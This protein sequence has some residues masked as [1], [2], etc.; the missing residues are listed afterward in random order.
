[1]LMMMMQE[2]D[3]V[4]IDIGERFVTAGYGWD[5]ILQ[6]QSKVRKTFLDIDYMILSGRA[7]VQQEADP[8]HL[9]VQGRAARLPLPRR[10]PQEDVQI[11]RGLE[12]AAL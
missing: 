1:M 7:P 3:S 10:D 5:K 12:D 8:P 6:Y 11:H 9:H 2:A 4:V